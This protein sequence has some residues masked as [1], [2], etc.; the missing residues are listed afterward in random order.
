[1]RIL[2]Q[3]ARSQGT[4]WEEYDSADW[5][6]LPSRP[7]PSGGETLDGERGWVCAVNVQGVI[8]KAD[9]IALEDLP[10]G[11]LRVLQWDDDPDDWDPGNFTVREVLFRPI[12]QDPAFGY[13]YNTQQTQ[14]VFAASSAQ[15]QL[16]TRKRSNF[17]LR[18]WEDFVPPNPALIRHG[19]WMPDELF[20]EHISSQSVRG[21]RHWSDGLPEIE[22]CEDG[23]IRQQRKL[24]RYLKPLGTRTYYHNSTDDGV[25]SVAKNNN[26]LSLAPA[27]AV[28][29]NETSLGETGTL[30]WAAVTPVNEPASA[31]WPAGNYRYQLDVV[32]ADVDVDYGLLTLGAANGNFRRYNSTL[33]LILESKQ[34]AEGAFSLTGLRLATTGSVTWSAGTADDRFAIAVAAIKTGGHGTATMQMQLGETDDFADGPWL[35]EGEATQNAVLHGTNF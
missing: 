5:A 31:A 12:V 22:K 6:S 21:W 10:G 25:L 13:A 16:A 34:Q 15:S 23:C 14:Q 17:T 11:V 24:D 4:D 9:H 3:W 7:V 35:A 27:G 1:M 2:V 26:R 20:N 28:T 19:I 29:E 18:D 32:A 33:T 8:F 30:Q